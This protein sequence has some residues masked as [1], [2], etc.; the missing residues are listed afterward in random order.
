MVKFTL[1]DDYQRAVHELYAQAPFRA[2]LKVSDGPKSLK[3]KT[4]K[5]QDLNKFEKLNRSL[6]AMMQQNPIDLDKV[7]AEK[8]EMQTSGTTA[9]AKGQKSTKKGKGKK[10]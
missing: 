3:F 9:T 5:M 2:M 6:M 7:E 8:L 10:K 4:D 1:W